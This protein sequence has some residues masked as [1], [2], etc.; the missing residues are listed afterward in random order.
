RF[1]EITGIA[2]EKYQKTFPNR[3]LAIKA[4][5]DMKKKIEKV[6]REENANSLE[7]KGKITFKKFYESKWLP[8]YELGQ[9]IRSNRPPS[10]ITISNT[11]DIFRLHILP[12]FGEY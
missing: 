4:E 10:D 3:Q 2:S 9:T 1:K 7:L 6:L 12:M 5:N 8:R 11:K